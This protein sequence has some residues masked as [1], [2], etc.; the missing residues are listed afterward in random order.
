MLNYISKPKSLKISA[1]K[2][3]YHSLMPSE[4][5]VVSIQNNNT[6]KLS[7]FCE[8]ENVGEQIEVTKYLSFCTKN[9]LATISCIGGLILDETKGENIPPLVYK[10]SSRKLHKG[11][12]VIS[13]NASLGKIA[14][15]NSDTNIILNGGISYLKFKKEYEFYAPAFFIVNYGADY[16][17]CITSGGGTQQNAKRDTL[18]SVP[19]PL[20]TISNHFRPNDIITFVSIL[21]QNIIHKEEEIKHKINLTENIIKNELEQNQLKNYMVEITKIS[22]IKLNNLRLDAGLYSD[23]Y[24]LMR[25]KIANYKNGVFSIP[26]ENLSSGSTPKIRVLGKKANYKWVTPT[27]VSDDGFFSPVE[28]VSMPSENNLNSDA[29][30]FINR[31]SKGKKGEYVGIA[32]FYDFSYYG[33][34][35]YNQGF[36]AL[37]DGYS[38]TQMKF[39]IAFMNSRIMR[40]ICGYTSQGTKM[41]EMKMTDFSRLIF[42][43]LPLLKQQKVAQAYYNP[44][45]NNSNLILEN[46]LTL[47][48]ERNKSLGIFQLNME[49]LELKEKLANVIDKIIKN[50]E[51]QINL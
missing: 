1:V 12:Y 26:Y 16:L 25:N 20:P 11:H 7:E 38:S 23:E 10:D 8:S 44:V 39:I 28:N 41:K 42:P 13:R 5:R 17:T 50:Q 2:N 48:F 22:H 46:Y 45:T 9:F 15:I 3:K 29:V 47:E 43:N 30:L 14:Y 37:K 35:H 32:S 33:A 36:Y 24:K 51:I 19:I 49:I 34:G 6:N 4:F 18:L 27:N 31:T 21:V 40:K